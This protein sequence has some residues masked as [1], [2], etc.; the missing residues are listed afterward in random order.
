CNGSDLGG[1]LRTPAAYCGVVGL[2]P[3]PGTVADETRVNAFS[4]LS[5]E[6]PLGRTVADCALLLSAML[7]NIPGSGHEPFAARPDEAERLTD[8][9]EVD[10][11]SLK[12]AFS[13]DLGFAPVS[14]QDR[15]LFRQRRGAFG[16]LFAE[17]Q[18]R[19][20]ELG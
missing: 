9:P 6:G 2:R 10:P 17:V 13:E 14:E 1:S 15:G 7:D 4:P 19:D 16:G 3:G 5:V 8:L 20:P 11:G 12:V 18:D